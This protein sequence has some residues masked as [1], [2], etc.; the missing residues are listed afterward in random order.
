LKNEK[1][2]KILEKRRLNFGREQKKISKKEGSI[3]LR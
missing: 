2:G 1:G 3:Y